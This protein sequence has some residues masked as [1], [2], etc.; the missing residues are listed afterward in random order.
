MRLRLRVK[1][2]YS[3]AP[4]D[5]FVIILDTCLDHSSDLG[6]GTGRRVRTTSHEPC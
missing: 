1:D 4:R 3:H 5:E 6:Q 2:I